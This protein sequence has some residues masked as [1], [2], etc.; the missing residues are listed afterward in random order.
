MAK[1][2][3]YAVKNTKEIFESWVECEPH[4]KG[5]KGVQYRKFKTLEE[6]NAFINGENTQQEKPIEKPVIAKTA[7]TE[8]K[9]AKNP[10]AINYVS[11]FGIKGTIT[12]AEEKDPFSLPLKGNIYAVDGSFNSKTGTYGAG[13]VEYDKKQN[14]I[15]TARISGTKPE[16]ATSH[17]IAGE[18]LA[19]RTAIDMAIQ[20]HQTEITLICDYEGDFKWTAPESVTINGQPCWGNKGKTPIAAFHKQSIKHAAANG[21]KKIHFVWVRG[22]KGID[23]NEMV[24][25]LAKEACGIE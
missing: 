4:V 21:I 10:K 23:A 2:Y 19:M 15:R 5:V 17:N 11:P 13:V 16:F 1:N 14:I 7:T 20:H 22:H 8:P 24:D 3:F 18:T 25:Q 9:K 12:A 6:A